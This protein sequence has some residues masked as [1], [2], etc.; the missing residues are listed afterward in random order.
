M[1][2]SCLSKEGSEGREAVGG[3]DV[4]KFGQSANGQVVR[5]TGG[6]LGG[7]A[8]DGR[9]IGAGQRMG[10]SIAQPLGLVPLVVDLGYPGEVAGDLRGS[11]KCGGGFESRSRGS[12]GCLVAVQSVDGRGGV[13]QVHVLPG[14]ASFDASPYPL[15]CRR[16][17]PGGL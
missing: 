2:C 16:N 11:R 5:A 8:V 13:G 6:G 9:E 12:C 10:K 7:M 15:S 14:V 3:G 1:I 17:E 4:E